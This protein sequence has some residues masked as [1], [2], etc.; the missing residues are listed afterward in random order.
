MGFK[1]KKSD[2]HLIGVTCCFIAS[3]IEDEVSFTMKD[4][5]TQAVHGKFT[6]PEIV[7]MEKDIMKTLEF[8]LIQNTLLDDILEK[9]ELLQAKLSHTRLQ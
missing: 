2:L 3:K 7:T 9:F 6:L 5:I 1:I 4:M 8:K